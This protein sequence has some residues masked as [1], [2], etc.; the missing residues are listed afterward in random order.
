MEEFGD[1]S[2]TDSLIHCPGQECEMEKFSS[3]IERPFLWGNKW[4]PHL[5]LTE[6]RQRYNETAGG[7]LSTFINSIW[8][9][10][11]CPLLAKT[12][13]SLVAL[14]PRVGRTAEGIW[15]GIA[16]KQQM[17]N[18]VANYTVLVKIT[19]CAAREKEMRWFIQTNDTSLTSCLLLERRICHTRFPASLRGKKL[20]C[21][22][23]T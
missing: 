5:Q 7:C 13:N 19:G 6:R 2:N 16:S 15:Q 10:F 22:C 23:N 8:S 1:A 12:H 21:E 20:A 3:G 4:H 14:V 17:E 18:R 11:C 9:C